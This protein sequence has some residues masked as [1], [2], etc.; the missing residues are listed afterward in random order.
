M[1]RLFFMV[2]AG[3]LWL[4]QA[5]TAAGSSGH[6]R[7]CLFAAEGAEKIIRYDSEG[8]VT[9]Y[10]PVPMARDGW[11]LPNRNILFSFNR[12]YDSARHDNPS[13]VMEVT[14]DKRVVFSFSITG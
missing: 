10:Y 9:W 3:M 4:A 11:L 7:P 6:F 8:K 13:G 14:P 5:A 2:F 12:E 1:S